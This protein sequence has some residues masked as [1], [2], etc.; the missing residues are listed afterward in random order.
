MANTYHSDEA[1]IHGLHII[2][3]HVVTSDEDI[4]IIQCTID[5]IKSKQ[6]Q[7][8]FQASRLRTAAEHIGFTMIDELQSYE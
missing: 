6:T 3:D 4:E 7:I 5:R 1:I 8:E 2:A